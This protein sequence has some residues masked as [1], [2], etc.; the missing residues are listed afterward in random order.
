MLNLRVISELQVTGSRSEQNV[1]W[2]WVFI[3]PLYLGLHSTLSSRAGRPRAAAA[4]MPRFSTRSSLHSNKNFV[5]L[6]CFDGGTPRGRKYILCIYGLIPLC[7][8]NWEFYL[9][10]LYF[11]DGQGG[12]CHFHL[13]DVH[14]HKTWPK[15]FEGWAGPQGHSGRGG[16]RQVIS[17]LL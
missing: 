7:V 11:T 16:D 10:L 14:F 3:A 9:V 5:Y 15:D 13:E 17:C 8:W 6:L 12:L 1:M 4:A 2:F